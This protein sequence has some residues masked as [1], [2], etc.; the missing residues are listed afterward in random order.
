MPP[1]RDPGA[2]RGPALARPSRRR[3]REGPLLVRRAPRARERAWRSPLSGAER[4]PAAALPRR[5]STPPRGPTR[6]AP[7][8]DRALSARARASR[9]RRGPRSARLTRLRWGSRSYATPPEARGTN[10][11]R[12]R[13][14]RRRAPTRPALAASPDS[15]GRSASRRRAPRAPG[16]GPRGPGP[17]ARVGSGPPRAPGAAAPRTRRPAREGR[18]VRPRSAL[19]RRV[20]QPGRDAALDRRDRDRSLVP[21]AGRPLRALR[22]FRGRG[23]PPPAARRV[24]RPCR[25]RGSPSV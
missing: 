8:R 11:R 21:G 1:P 9:A 23:T 14:D 13:A 6:R 22:T 16:P 4:S 19:R 24:E 17:G 18:F 3:S 10:A 5:S 15:R 25:G 2:R 7:P 20:R 12:D